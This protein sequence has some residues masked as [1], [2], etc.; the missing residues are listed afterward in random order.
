MSIWQS[1]VFAERALFSDRLFLTRI[2]RQTELGSPTFVRLR[3]SLMARPRPL[4]F[5]LVAFV[6]ARLTE[7]EFCKH[8]KQ[9]LC[10]AAF[11]FY[12]FGV[13][14][15]LDTKKPIALLGVD[16][17]ERFGNILSL[18][19]FNVIFMSS[20]IR[21]AT[22]VS[23][24]ADMLAFK[25]E[26]KIAC[27]LEYFNAHRDIFEQI[28]AYGYEINS[29]DFAI[30]EKY[31]N[32]VAL[33]QAII[34][35]YV[36]GLKSACTNKLLDLTSNMGYEYLSIKQGYSKCST[37]ILDDNAVISADDGI[38]SAASKIGVDTLKISNG[39]NNISLL[40]YDYGFIG[41]ASFTFN[42]NVYFFGNIDLHADAKK[43]RSFC[44]SHGFSII[45]LDNNK[46]CDVGGAII[47]PNLKS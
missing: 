45:S 5:A 13:I 10:E 11:L 1:V 8:K 26:N 28:E 44:E 15:M 31:P 6:Q 3:L 33:N 34:K 25:I 2:V 40:G 21:L 29:F 24:H 4:L 22:P 46:L 18:L 7:L 37:L 9:F 42:K 43:I 17:K 23:S 38:I 35:K 30:G 39:V 19:G 32:D 16:A 14:F 27:N 12:Y 20:D 36:L 41:G 47:L